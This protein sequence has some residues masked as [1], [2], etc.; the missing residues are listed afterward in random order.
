M[1]IIVKFDAKTGDPF[2]KVVRKKNRKKNTRINERNYEI[3]KQWKRETKLKK[4][5]GTIEIINERWNERK[6]IFNERKE[7]S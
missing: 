1:K 6:E 7:N 5:E 3:K 4:K 2:E